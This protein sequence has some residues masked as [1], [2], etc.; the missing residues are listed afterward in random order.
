MKLS[1]FFTVPL[2]MH[3]SL[4]D[5]LDIIKYVEAYMS[6]N[7]SIPQKKYCAVAAV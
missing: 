7:L 3:S 2:D 5:G 1:A 4:I 6:G